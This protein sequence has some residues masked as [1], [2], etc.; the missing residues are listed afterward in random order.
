M[1]GST[2]P[3]TE[4]T[5]PTAGRFDEVIHAPQRLRICAFLDALSS[6]EFSTLRDDLGVADS[7][8]SKHLKVLRDAGYVEIDKPTGRGRVRTWIELT[9]AGRAA[10]TSHVLALREILG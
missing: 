3:M 2:G 4:S 7:V 8:L 10:Y 6:V 9:P 5:G 1:T